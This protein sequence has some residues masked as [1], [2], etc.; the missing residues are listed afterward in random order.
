M[1]I[2]CCGMER[3]GSTV[4]FQI[5]AQLVEDAGLG[6]RVEWVKAERVS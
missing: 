1:W 6:K 5:S 2:F 4:Q 3:S